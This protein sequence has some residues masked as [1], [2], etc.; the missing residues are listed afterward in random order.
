M[1]QAW[2]RL[3][4]D[5]DEAYPKRLTS[6]GLVAGEGA[7]I[8]CPACGRSSWL[9][10]PSRRL[11]WFLEAISIAC[12]QACG[13]FGDLSTYRPKHEATCPA[14]FDVHISC[15]RCGVS[16]ATD[17]AVVRRP[18]CAIENPRE[19][20][21]EAGSFIQHTMAGASGSRIHVELALAFLVSQFDGLMRSMLQIARTN[22]EYC[23]THEPTDAMLSRRVALPATMSFQNLLAARQRLLPSGWDMANAVLNWSAL[24]TLFQKRHL[25]VHRLGI[26]DQEYAE[27]TGHPRSDIGRRVPLTEDEVLAGAQACC[28]LV[29]TF[30]GN[31]L[32]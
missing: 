10:L 15:R 2:D 17:G 28:Q 5:L 11:E 23:H 30:F 32:S 18:C 16:V 19:V 29:V 7:V 26:I 21:A 4:A 27:K 22:A 1:M 31:F 6:L 9:S 14:G 12:P 20:M 3:Q 25:L 13:Y 8:I 24:T